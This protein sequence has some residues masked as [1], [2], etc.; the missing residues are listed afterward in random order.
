MMTKAYIP[1]ATRSQCHA[2]RMENS[3]SF[4]NT[5]AK[6]RELDGASVVELS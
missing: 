6:M 5:F 2:V 3:V 4:N 1:E